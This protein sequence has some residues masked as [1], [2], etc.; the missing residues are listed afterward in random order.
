M[1]NTCSSFQNGFTKKARRE[2]DQANHPRKFSVPKLN[3]EA[4]IYV[5]LIDWD[6]VDW[7]EPPMT[8]KLS[9]D[10]VKSAQDAPLVLPA[11][12]N[13][14]Q[15]VEH[16]I[17]LVTEACRQ[18]VGSVNRHRWILNTIDSRE[19]RAKFESKKDDMCFE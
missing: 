8:M 12:P 6:S 10:A 7:T 14:T 5:D 11:Y 16:M 13:H 19:K 2:F 4:K 1:V 18:R 9:I 15:S 17:P 3:F